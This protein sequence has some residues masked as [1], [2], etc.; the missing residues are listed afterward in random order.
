MDGEV[1]RLKRRADP[2]EGTRLVQRVHKNLGRITD[3]RL[4]GLTHQHQCAMF[5][6]VVRD[7]LGMPGDIF[8]AL[9]DKIVLAPGRPEPCQLIFEEA[10]VLQRV[11]GTAFGFLNDLFSIEGII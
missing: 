10:P 6:V 9:P 5:V 4:A 8:G 11:S 2:G 1:Q 3:R 7:G